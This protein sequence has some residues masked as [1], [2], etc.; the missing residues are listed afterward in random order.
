[1]LLKEGIKAPAFTLTDQE[2]R[3]VALKDF[4]GKKVVLYFYP[5]D[6][7]P[8]CTREA[9]GFQQ[10]L[11]AIKRKGA[12]VIGVSK[13]SE[14][15]HKKFCEKYGLQFPLLADVEGVVVEKYGVWQEKNM[16]GKKSMGIVRTTYVIDEAGKIARVF[17]RVKVDGHLEQVLGVL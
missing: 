10:S 7:T 9:Q 5:K 12:V 16:Y 13:D 2:G 3:K 11:A 14:A 17:A 1:V 6:M 15:S 4:A 8:G